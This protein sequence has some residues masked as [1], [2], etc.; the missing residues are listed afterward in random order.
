MKTELENTDQG[1]LKDSPAR[2]R[3]YTIVM[4]LISLLIFSHLTYN[5]TEV[6]NLIPICILN[7]CFWISRPFG[8][9]HN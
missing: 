3:L 7:I 5:L 6:F 1:T 4:Q 2:G 9:P 8:H